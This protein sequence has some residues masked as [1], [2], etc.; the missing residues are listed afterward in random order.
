[1][2]FVAR[3]CA[4]CRNS[5]TCSL[6]APCNAST[7]TA[8]PLTLSFEPITKIMSGNLVS[9]NQQHMFKI[10]T[11]DVVLVQPLPVIG[12]TLAALGKSQVTNHT[13]QN[14]HAR[15]STG[16]ASTS[17]QF[18]R[19]PAFLCS[20]FLLLER[21]SATVILN[22]TKSPA[23]R[24]PPTCLPCSTT[25]VS[26]LPHTSLSPSASS[27]SPSGFPSRGSSP[28]SSHPTPAWYFPQVTESS[29]QYSCARSGTVEVRNG[30]Q[31][32][33]SNM[34]CGSRLA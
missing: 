27:P 13:R 10:S 12:T 20:L 23:R 30:R 16:Q 26:G 8:T 2:S 31:H 4:A 33:A 24:R 22:N 7:P 25:S 14:G 28:V 9:M 19:L 6:K 18:P 5:C 17:T 1:M 11:C 34:S 29:P 32:E 3:I 15:L 21:F